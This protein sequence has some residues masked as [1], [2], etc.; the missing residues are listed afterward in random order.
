MAE[1]F[2]S[3]AD[4][5]HFD[6]ILDGKRYENKLNEL[7]RPIDVGNINGEFVEYPAR[8]TYVSYFLREAE[9]RL[10]SARRDLDTLDAQ[11]DDSVRGKM[12]AIKEQDPKF[13][14]TETT[15]K[16]Q[17]K[18]DPRYVKQTT[19][20]DGLSALYKRLLGA[21]ESLIERRHALISLGAQ[22][23]D[24][25][26]S[27]RIVDR[28]EAKER[29]RANNQQVAMAGGFPNLPGAP[30]LPAPTQEPLADSTPPVE[31]V[32]ETPRRGRRA[33]VQS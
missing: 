19:L 9:I 33:P 4:L 7:G 20:V 2:N 8:Y 1:D 24:G 29:A 14:V 26:F 3:V 27:A 5:M 30:G 28:D 16:Q 25:N 15:V 18:A 10:D 6:I 21:R 31:E 17:I 13:K 12:H 11:L 32:P 23:R 22:L